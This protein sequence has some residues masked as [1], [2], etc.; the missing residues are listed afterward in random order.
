M[1]E[2]STDGSIQRGMVAEHGGGSLQHGGGSLQHGGGARH[3]RGINQQSTAAAAWQS[4][5]AA[6]FSMAWRR[7]QPAEHGMAEAS[8]G[9]A[10]HGS[11]INRRSRVAAAL[12]TAWQ[13]HQS[14]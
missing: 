2:A 9:G 5:A 11:C 10:Q 7:H 6:A 13:R 3:G 1:A 12:S 8:T 4:T 14:T